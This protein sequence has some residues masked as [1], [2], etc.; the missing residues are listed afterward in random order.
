MADYTRNFSTYGTWRS[1]KQSRY[2]IISNSLLTPTVNVDTFFF[3]HA[4]VA[5]LT[6]IVLQ[7]K[8]LAQRVTFL[9]L[10]CCTSFWNAGM[11]K[12]VHRPSNFRQLTQCIC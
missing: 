8:S 7:L 4:S 3:G 1:P 9:E 12:Y 10:Q 6:P 11:I 2:L 5:H